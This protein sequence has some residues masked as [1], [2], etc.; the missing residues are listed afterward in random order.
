MIPPSPSYWDCEKKHRGRA[1]GAAP[2]LFAKLLPVDVYKDEHSEQM[3]QAIARIQDNADAV[4]AEE[5]SVAELSRMSSDCANY[6][7]FCSCVA[8][9]ITGKHFA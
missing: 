4:H 6:R 1:P 3:L 5:S 7:D 2:R 8:R 9:R